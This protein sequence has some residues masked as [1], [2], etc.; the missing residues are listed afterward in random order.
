MKKGLHFHELLWTLC[1]NII[2]GPIVCGII[3]D[4][5]LVMIAWLIEHCNWMVGE[6]DLLW[7]P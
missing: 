7:R 5:L 2:D 3:Q 1:S 4:A 6:E